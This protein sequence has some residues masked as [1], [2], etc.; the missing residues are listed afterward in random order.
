MSFLVR[1]INRAKWFQFD[2][3]KFDEVSADAVTNC[4]KTT[5]NTLSVWH[6]ESEED[7]ENAVLAIV[8]NQ[9]HIETVDFVILDAQAL[10][11]YNLNIVFTPGDTPVKSLVETHR[12]VS[13]LSY[14]K[15]GHVKEHLVQRIRVDKIKRY[16]ASSIKKILSKALSD[17]LIQIEDLK[18]S[19]RGKFL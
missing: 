17:G 10:I 2:I 15:L 11:E 8:A 3:L 9:D 14:T 1:K 4:L 6:I 5:G 18:E 12:D 13:G 16:T 19:I 7:I